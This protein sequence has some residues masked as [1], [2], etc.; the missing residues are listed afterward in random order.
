MHYRFYKVPLKEFSLF[1][2]LI[3]SIILVFFTGCIRE[4]QPEMPAMSQP[5][6]GEYQEGKFVWYDLYTDDIDACVLF[7]KQL[8]AWSFQDTRN[9]NVKTIL[10]E[11]SPI[12]D[13]VYMEPLKKEVKESRWL[14][15]ISVPDVNGVSMAAQENQGRLYSKPKNSPNRGRVAVVVDPQGAIFGIMKATGGD[16]IDQA[17]LDNLWMGSELW[18]LDKSEAISFYKGVIGYETMQVDMGENGQYTFLTT[19]EKAR[20]GV[21][22]ITWEHIKPAWLPYISVADVVEVADKVEALGG[23]LLV[24]PNPDIRDENVAIIADPSGAVF[25]I[26]E[27]PANEIEEN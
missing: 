20:A 21:V 26:Q 4:V 12:G 1:L 5:A 19:G 25:A 17:G 3:L 16:P 8:F 9:P 7:Y 14:G 22:E 15:Y 24:A 2:V 23:K 6:T 11:G 27:L 10:R 13:A 18:A